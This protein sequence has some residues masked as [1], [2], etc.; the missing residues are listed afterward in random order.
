MQR[1]KAVQI[2]AQG[3]SRIWC[4]TP[5]ELWKALE[6]RV[7]AYGDRLRFKVYH[8]AFEPDPDLDGVT[9]LIVE[10]QL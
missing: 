1:M 3:G 8:V 2:G 5:E 4:D 9:V 6:S 7:L 10:T